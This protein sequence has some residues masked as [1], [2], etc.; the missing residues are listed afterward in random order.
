MNESKEL[1]WKG[2]NKSKSIAR[3]ISNDLESNI[4]STRWSNSENSKIVFILA[5][6]LCQY[7]GTFKNF[8]DWSLKHIPDLEI[9]SMDFGGHGLSSGTRGHIED[10]ENLVQDQYQFVNTISEIENKKYYFIGHGLGGLVFLDLYNR[11]G[12]KFKTKPSGIILTNFILNLDHLL[13]H[14]KK[15]KNPQI[16]KFLMHLRIG[17]VFD[18]KLMS[19][20]ADNTI[21]LEEDPLIHFSP[22]LKSISE[23]KKKAINIY[24]DAYY[25]DLPLMIGRSD[26]DSYINQNGM[27]YFVKGVKKELLFEKTYSNMR[28]DLYNEIESEMFFN[29]I[30]T[31]LK[32]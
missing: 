19:L 26:N 15:I 23:V 30:K 9:Y 20:K 13:F 31:W 27:N 22:T 14:L 10:F 17:K 29:D 8:I 7:H 16:S 28:H 1:N 4:Y 18:S 21:S 24:Q 2:I 5:H 3:F 6:D 12:Q 25:I 32:I 11:F